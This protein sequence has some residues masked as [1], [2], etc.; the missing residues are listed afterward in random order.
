MSKS[1]FS[2]L[3]KSKIGLQHYEDYL[4]KKNVWVSVRIASFIFFNFLPCFHH[5]LPSITGP[6][7]TQIL[8]AMVTMENSTLAECVDKGANRSGAP[9]KGPNPE[10][11]HY[12]TWQLAGKAPFSGLVLIGPDSE[13]T[14]WEKPYLHSMC[15]KQSAAIAEHCRCLSSNTSYGK[16][17][18]GETEQF[19]KK[20]K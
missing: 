6:L 9:Q 20:K 1:T 16:Q 17:E 10:N 4:L 5:F 12:M 13:P 11:Y 2:Q 19:D 8:V 14:Q 3:W 15:W 7:K 18:A